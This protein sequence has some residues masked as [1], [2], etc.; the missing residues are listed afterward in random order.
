MVMLAKVKKW[1]NS[2]GLIVPADVV[3]SQGIRD[4]DVLEVEIRRKS[5]SPEE[6]G[7]TVEFKTDLAAL[8][9]EVEEGWKDL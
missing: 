3:R 4:G 1:G 7:G 2:L 6:L 8:L 9:R 5:P